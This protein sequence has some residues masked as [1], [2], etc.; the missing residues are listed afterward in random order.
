[1]K[2]ILILGIL[3]CISMGAYSQNRPTN[4]QPFWIDPANDNNGHNGTNP[5]PAQ[6]ENDFRIKASGNVGIGTINPNA[7]AALEVQSTTKG[8]LFPRLLQVQINN[9]DN[10]PKGLVLFNLTKNCLQVN[11]G[12]GA[13]PDWRCINQ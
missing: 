9:L 2:N 11:V 12:T 4:R 6:Q 8:V 3:L 13:S 7:S 10:P 5:T 1:M